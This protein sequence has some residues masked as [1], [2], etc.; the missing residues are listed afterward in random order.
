MILITT[1]TGAD[2]DAVAS[3]L[4]ASKLYP[5]AKIYLPGSPEKKVRQYINEKEFPL[6]FSGFKDIE[7]IK[8]DRVVVVDTSYPDRIGRAAGLITDKT[9]I[10]I[11]D[12]HPRPE[13]GSGGVRA[14][15]DLHK[16]WGATV[17]ILVEE[18]RKK[19][20]KLSPEEAS[21]LL[22][23]IYEDTGCLTY[24]I[25]TRHDIEAVSWLLEEGADLNTVSRYAVSNLNEEQVHLL[26][27]L[28]NNKS[29]LNIGKKKIAVTWDVLDDYIEE[30]AVVVRKFT[31]TVSPDALFAILKI[32]E[33]ILCIARSRDEDIN[34][35][36]IISDLGGSGGHRS[37]A[38][39][40]F[41]ENSVTIEE[42]KIKIRESLYNNIGK[43]EGPSK[44][45]SKIIPRDDTARRAYHTLNHLNLK[46]APVGGE[47]GFIDGLVLREELKK[48]I[49]HGL[50]EHKVL[51]FLTEKVS[52]D[53][54]SENLLVE[55]A[56]PEHTIKPVYRDVKNKFDSNLSGSGRDIIRT[57]AD[58]AEEMDIEAYCVGGM[59]RDMILD[60]SH[61]DI[62]IVVKE[63]ANEFSRRLAEALNGSYYTHGK[64]R[65]AVVN[66]PGREIDIAT[67]RKEYYE[68]RAALPE[69]Q[70][71]TLRQDLARRDF[72]INAMAVQ[73]APAEEYGQLIDYFGGLK[74]IENK[75]IRILYPLSFVEDPTRIF[76]AARF[77]K[78]FNFEMTSATLSQLK[79][80]INMDIQDELTPDRIKEE[81]FKI[82]NEDK[83]SEIIS[84]LNS[85]G[86]FKCIDR[87]LAV[88]GQSLDII[89]SFDRRA[90]SFKDEVREQLKLKKIN[91]LL[92]AFISGLP[93]DRGMR[94][95]K[96][97]NFSNRIKKAFKDFKSRG[98][99]LEKVLE[100]DLSPARIFKAVNKISP[101]VLYYILIRSSSER[102]KENIM[103]YIE[104]IKVMKPSLS[105][106]DLIEMGYEPSRRFS[107]MLYT[108]RIAKI[109]GLFGSADDEK[110]FLSAYFKNQ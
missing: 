14:D 6:E 20:I 108:L 98:G 59:V 84:R 67:L 22:T 13:E 17:A 2:F 68:V 37:A 43:K 23:G 58:S 1:H 82:L 44:A 51:E 19:D 52:C 41:K 8:F 72:S 33:N 71:G 102:V 50:G 93:Q 103:D 79:K 15:F 109:N 70:K 12:H 47:K 27:R 100:R 110:K 73:I 106:A 39:V 57:A 21:V 45:G 46:Y 28:L 42:L 53:P 25:T 36:D 83:A 63:E 85:L 101:L 77:E 3:L 90:E 91:I 86:A 87:E 60:I 65:T 92:L 30:L 66:I 69:V 76:R 9:E 74:D 61:A 55:D 88:S 54:A 80:T 94:M 96:I 16:L 26:D 11:Y 99:R 24:P 4:A 49:K 78:R 48:A 5:G 35:S 18:I 56:F 95:L 31:D 10:F 7:D 105:G 64:F 34:L 32:K 89:K 75:K 62:D 40:S 81:I 29:F 38:T 104:S 107:R 97:F